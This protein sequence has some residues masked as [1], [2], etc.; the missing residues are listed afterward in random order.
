[1]SV[2]AK[3]ALE[4]LRIEAEALKVAEKAANYATFVG[5]LS[6]AYDMRTHEE[7]NLAISLFSELCPCFPPVPFHLMNARKMALEHSYPHFSYNLFNRGSTLYTAGTPCNHVIFL[8]K[9]SVKSEVTAKGGTPSNCI[10]SLLAAGNIIGEIE[11]LKSDGRW[12]S[13]GIGAEKGEYL[14]INKSAF[15][16]LFELGTYVSLSEAQTL[17][18]IRGFNR[19]GSIE[20][21]MTLCTG[22]QRKIYSAGSIYLK[23]GDPMISTVFVKDG[24]V[25]VCK[26]MP[27]DVQINTKS[28]EPFDFHE[29]R[30][31]F[32]KPQSDKEHLVTLSMVGHDEMLCYPFK[33]SATIPTSEYTYIVHT[34][35]ILL[36]LNLDQF[37]G[38]LN[39]SMQGR[40]EIRKYMTKFDGQ[41][42]DRCSNFSKASEHVGNMMQDR[43][44]KIPW[45]EMYS[46][47]EANAV[48]IP[49]VVLPE[50][51]GSPSKSKAGQ[52]TA[53][54]SKIGR[55]IFV[56]LST[57]LINVRKNAALSLDAAAVSDTYSYAAVS[58]A[59]SF[60]KYQYDKSHQERTRKFHEKRLLEAD[61]SFSNLPENSGFSVLLRRSMELIGTFGEGSLAHKALDSKAT[62]FLQTK[63]V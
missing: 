33:Q 48:M 7:H 3:K 47:R 30:S 15:A 39:I 21:L 28:G 9:G 60:L 22:I 32:F 57:K 16:H 1:M 38:K 31:H 59:Q 42:K 26:K 8:M 36:L 46:A 55:E 5:I 17:M 34:G 53:L 12:Q 54:I 44:E 62:P 61:H 52:N 13:T 24:S 10:E 29:Y 41:R 56:S 49:P 23:E 14:S 6:K 2:E 25:R 40:H 37:K 45:Q 43:S 51:I 35:S 27:D 58:K 20:T 18:R 4:A 50:L 63:S 19:L 11:A